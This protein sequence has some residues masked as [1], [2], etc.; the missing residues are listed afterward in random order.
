MG[1]LANDIVEEVNIKPN[2]TKRIIRIVIG[3]ATSLIVVAFAF[4]Q[5]KSSFFNRM[6]SLEEKLDG[7]T[8]DIEQLTTDMNKGFD[9]VDTKIDKIYSDGL[10]IFNNFQEY[11]DAQ[12]GLIIDYGSGNKD[13]LK[14][15]LEISSMKQTQQVESQIETAK[16]EEPTYK[17]EVEFIPIDEEGR[18]LSI[19]VTSLRDAPF[20]SE[21]ISI[22]V[23]TNDTTFYISGATKK[24][25][26][27]I[28]KNKYDVGALI[29]SAKYPNRYDFAYRNK[30]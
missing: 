24:Y 29:D 10:T 7:Q 22:E 15:M 6:D 27:G 26:D 9:E 12:L 4:G 18:N 3:I 19:A 20:M 2:N 13:M 16:K 14:R 21:S 30:R 11:N 1:N 17:G 25:Y 8:I 5:F 23:E 28:N